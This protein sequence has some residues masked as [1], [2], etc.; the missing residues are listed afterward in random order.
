MSNMA[1]K[2]R[3][4]KRVW[5]HM[6]F[7]ELDRVD[8]SWEEIHHLPDWVEAV[9]TERPEQYQTPAHDEGFALLVNG[10]RYEYLYWT[11]CDWG[12]HGHGNA[13]YY[14]AFYRRRR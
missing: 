2:T 7:M 12:A 1:F 14:V 6:A 11:Y 8:S 3:R 9:L 13:E 5:L 4:G 10:K